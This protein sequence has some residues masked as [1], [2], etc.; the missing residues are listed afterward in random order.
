M[1]NPDN[2]NL[3]KFS[4]TSDYD[5]YFDDDDFQDFEIDRELNQLLDKADLDGTD[6]FFRDEN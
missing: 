3:S 1:Q 2:L 6:E 4:Q 5:S